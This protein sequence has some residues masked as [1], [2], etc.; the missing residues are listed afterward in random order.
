MIPRNST[1]RPLGMEERRRVEEQEEEQ[2]H[3]KDP[4]FARPITLAITSSS[5]V[6]VLCEY[7]ARFSFSRL[8]GAGLE[9]GGDMRTLVG[10]GENSRGQL[11]R[12]AREV[13]GRSPFVR[14]SDA[15]DPALLA[16]SSRGGL[17][18]C[19]GMRREPD[20]PMEFPASG[21]S[22]VL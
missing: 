20:V 1:S 5:H 21:P 22:Q 14:R 18:S 10:Q 9:V 15:W 13:V 8:G 19:G 11:T 6:G 16:A 12:P 2:D 7:F 4:G 17:A 3:R